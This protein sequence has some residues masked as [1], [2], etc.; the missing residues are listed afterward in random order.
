MKIKYYLS[1]ILLLFAYSCKD[2]VTYEHFESRRCK[3]INNSGVEVVVLVKADMEPEVSFVLKQGDDVQ[4][5]AE[6][7]LGGAVETPFVYG[8]QDVVARV[9]FNGTTLVKYQGYEAV[10]K[11]DP[12]DFNAYIKEPIEEDEDECVYTFTVEDYQNALKQE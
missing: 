9:C 4:W 8:L 6:S 5:T 7:L 11:R 2:I 3:M 1:I 12:R 10:G